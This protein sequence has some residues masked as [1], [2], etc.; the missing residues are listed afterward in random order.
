[1]L[2]L[3]NKYWRIDN[4]SHLFCCIKNHITP[5]SFMENIFPIDNRLSL[6][7]IGSCSSLEHNEI[8]IVKLCSKDTLTVMIVN[9]THSC[10]LK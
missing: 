9:I 1:M 2:V 5:F 10:Q 3:W 7:E 8:K 4:L 6:K